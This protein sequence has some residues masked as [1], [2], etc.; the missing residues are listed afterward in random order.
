MARRRLSWQ[1]QACLASLL[2]CFSLSA[3]AG[4]QLRLSVEQLH[5]KLNSTGLVILDS[6]SPEDYQQDHIPG[7][8]N[9]PEAWSYNDKQTD[10]RIV[11][12]ARIQAVLQSLGINIDTPLVI[13]DEG[14]MANAARLFWTLEVYGLTNIK[15]LDQGYDAWINQNY[16]VNAD[17]PKTKKSDYIP[18]INH[19]RLATKLTTLIATKTPNQV[20]IDARPSDAYKGLVSSAKRF[21]HIP[22]AI[23]IPASHNLTQNNQVNSLKS[24][25]ELNKLYTTIPKENKIILYCAIGRIS[26]TNY[27]ALRELGYKVANYDASW[28]EW[29]NDFTLPIEK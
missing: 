24:P 11:Q 10:G 5:Q 16:P 18:A 22:S 28:K 15:V 17:V 4:Q 29:G 27:L 12:P 19:D 13:Y 3:S 20:I 21:G 23:N 26:A 2:F 6:R 9:F 14:K 25:E 1:R 7:A 8:L